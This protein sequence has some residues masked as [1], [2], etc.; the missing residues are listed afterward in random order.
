MTR[1]MSGCLLSK[2][3]PPSGLQLA[4]TEIP[5]TRN[6]SVQCLLAGLRAANCDARHSDALD[7]LTAFGVCCVIRCARDPVYAMVTD[8]LR[9]QLQLEPLAN[10]ACEE[11][12]NRM[13]LPA[14]GL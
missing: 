12:S 11:P 3:N 5:Q 1:E 6:L 4:D 8:D 14:G 13:L 2:Y 9:A 7:A 10:D